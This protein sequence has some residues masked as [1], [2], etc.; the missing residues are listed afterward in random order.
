MSAEEAEELEKIESEITELGR[1]MLALRDQ[2][3]KILGGR[4]AVRRHKRF[5]IDR[6]DLYFGG[7]DVRMF[8]RGPVLKKN[9]EPAARETESASLIMLDKIERAL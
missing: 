1:R 2:A 6:A 5:R 9:G 8:I 3:I 4:I 7:G